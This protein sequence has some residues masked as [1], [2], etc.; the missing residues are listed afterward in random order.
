MKRDMDR[1]RSLLFETESV[2]DFFSLDRSRDDSDR[3]NGQ[4]LVEAGL[5]DGVCHP[6]TSC[7]QSMAPPR[8]TVKRLTWE[9]HEFL[10]DIRQQEIWNRIKS[11]FK[12]ASFSTIVNVGKQL[13]ASYAKKKVERLLKDP[14]S[15]TAL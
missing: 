13:A 14:D 3:Y 10:D 8:V 5:L 15:S 12:D 6:G 9:G 11:D 1:I 2:D 4:L 7:D